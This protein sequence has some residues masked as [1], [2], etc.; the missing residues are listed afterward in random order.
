MKKNIGWLLVVLFAFTIL[1]VNAASKN[2]FYADD[3][4]LLKKDIGVTTFVAGNSVDVKSNIDGLAFVAGNDIDISSKQDY[5]FVAGNSID[6]ENATAKDVFAAGSSITLENSS[7][8][9]FFGA[10]EKITIDSDISRDAY[11]GADTVVIN[12]KIGGDVKV[13][14]ETIKIGEG[15]EI[16][17]KLLYPEDAKLKI[18]DGAKVENKKTYKTATVEVEEKTAYELFLVEFL[19]FIKT[20]CSMIIIG[21]LLLLI[22]PGLFEDFDKEERSFEVVAKR[23][24]IGIA[25]LFVAPIAGLIVLI[26]GIGAPLALI[27]FSLYFILFYLS[28]IPTAYY[29]G[30]WILGDQIENNYLLLLVS[31]LAMY[32]LMKVPFIGG[33]ITFISLC[34]GLGFFAIVMVNKISKKNETVKKKK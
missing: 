28:V 8:R 25:V 14:A 21:M 11:L 30:K 22:N 18:A 16:S 32:V 12:S 26:T 2:G 19:G 10:A 1:P 33:L 17:G 29:F 4:V 13:A 3:D 7:V 20:I 23:F 27:G 24:G 15:A 34:T 31:I 6:I 5:L 9:D